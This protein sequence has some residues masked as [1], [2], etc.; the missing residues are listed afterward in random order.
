MGTPLSAGSLPMRRIDR[1]RRAT[2]EPSSDR[3][4]RSRTQSWMADPGMPMPRFRF[5]IR[6]LMLTIAVLAVALGVGRPRTP[7]SGLSTSTTY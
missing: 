6:T 5:R 4:T 1:N 2:N 7:C 3:P